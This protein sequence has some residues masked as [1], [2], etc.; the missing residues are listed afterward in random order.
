MKLSMPYFQNKVMELEKKTGSLIEYLDQGSSMLNGN[1]H[2]V[3]GNNVSL[4]KE[5][6]ELFLQINEQR[7]CISSPDLVI[8][9]HHV[10]STEKTI[11]EVKDNKSVVLLEY[12]AWWSG[13][14]NFKLVEPEMDE[15][16]D[17]LAY[18]FYLW[19]SPYLQDT[20]FKSF[21]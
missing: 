4:Y 12:A 21:L 9:Y 10:L 2:I 20:L 17:Y 13:I 14:P 6:D 11:F 15:D 18:I 3:E 5:D 19:K 1:C 8:K 16:E 7:W